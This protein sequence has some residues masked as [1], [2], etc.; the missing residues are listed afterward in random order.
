MMKK[1]YVLFLVCMFLF[2]TAVS[3][4]SAKKPSVAVG[5][6]AAIGCSDLMTAFNYPNTTLTSVIS[7][8]AGPV[9]SG[10]IVYN[11]PDHCVVKGKMNE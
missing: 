9:T 7:Q 11:L 4:V 3:E 10:G 6:T 1:K 2:V 8:A 5:A